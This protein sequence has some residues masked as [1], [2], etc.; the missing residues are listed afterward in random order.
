MISGPEP[1]VVHTDRLINPP[2]RSENDLSVIQLNFQTHI[3]ILIQ[4]KMPVWYHQSDTILQG[5]LIPPWLFTSCHDGAEDLT[6][7]HLI[8][9]REL[10]HSSIPTCIFVRINELEYSYIQAG[11]SLYGGREIIICNM[12]SFSYV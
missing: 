12:V 11:S 7:D 3:L 4:R 9:V 8:R 5:P 1:K 2:C 6:R 10:S